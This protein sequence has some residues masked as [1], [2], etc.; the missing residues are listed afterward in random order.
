MEI[1]DR[2]KHQ[3]AEWP[4][5]KLAVL[6][7]STARGKARPKSD[8]DLGILLDPYSPELRFQV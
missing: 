4:E 5:L 1:L 8:V 6:F 2:L 7:G 3:A